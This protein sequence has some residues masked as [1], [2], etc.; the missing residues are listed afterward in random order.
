[1]VQDQNGRPRRAVLR[2]AETVLVLALLAAASACG[3][4][5]APA[6]HAFG[7]GRIT[8]SGSSTIAPLVSEIGKRF[9]AKYPGVRVDVQTG[10]SSRG[11]T[12]ARRGTVNIG[13]VSRALNTSEEDLTAHR[14]AVDGVAIILHASNGVPA[15][16]DRQIVGIYTGAITHWSAVGGVNAPITVVN[17]AEGR[18]TLE[19]FSNHFSIPRERI[20]ASVVI[21]ENLHGVRTVAGDPNA[22][23]Y[24]SVGTAE[25]EKSK[26]V[27]I[28][29][30]PMNGVEPTT[31]TV[32]QG[33]F[34]LSRPLNLVTIGQRS[35][36]IDAF[37]AM[38]ASPAVK[39][40]V[41]GQFFVPVAD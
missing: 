25:F 40:L 34:P 30:L 38:A 20:K 41:E 13:M 2:V 12:D 21:G 19:L 23:G 37:V 6:A 16:T 8:L 27:P 32:R 36:L 11:V 3:T 29:M 5:A 26:G 10:G 17:K 28:K 14:I 35:P 7:T 18:S 33:R 24:V 31:A 22:I 1:V 39:D 15:L 4:P 9:E